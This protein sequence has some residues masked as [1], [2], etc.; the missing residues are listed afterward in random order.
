MILGIRPEDFSLCGISAK[1]SSVIGAS[2]D[3]IKT[4]G[5]HITVDLTSKS[6]LKFIVDADTSIKINRQDVVKVHI[7]CEKP[8]IFEPEKVGKNITLFLGY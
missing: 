5:S 6:N 8:H 4:L 2:I 3:V 7:D 1:T